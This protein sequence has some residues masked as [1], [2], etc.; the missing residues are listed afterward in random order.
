[1]AQII[2]TY[3]KRSYKALS[4]I[5][6]V[7]IFFLGYNTYLMDRSLNNLRFALEMTGNVKSFEDAK[8]ISKILE[9]AL[10]M[11]VS[12]KELL[13]SNIAK[14]ELAKEILSKPEN[15]S[16]IEKDAQKLA[17][18]LHSSLVEE[19]SYESLDD[20]NMPLVEF[21]SDIFS[22]PKDISQL[23]DARF[24][25]QEVVKKKEEKRSPILLA[26]DKIGRF[27]APPVTTIS[28]SRLR[29][30]LKRTQRELAETSDTTKRQELN[31]QLAALQ[32]Y[33]SEFSQ[34]QA[35]YQRV[36]DL[37]HE[38]DLA[39]KAQFNI[40]WNEKLRGNSEE[41]IRMFEALSQ[42]FGKE[43]IGVFS[44]YQ[45]AEILRKNGEY[46]KAVSAYQEVAS[47]QPQ[48]DLGKMATFQTGSTYL[49]DLKE[50]DK[51]EQ[52]FNQY[53]A[54]SDDSDLAVHVKKEVIP[55]LGK[56]YRQ[57]GFGLLEQGYTSK[58]SEKFAEALKNFE[59]ALEINSRDGFSYSGKA[60]V[61]L[62]LNDPDKA[63]QF[64]R[65]AVKLL[66]RNEVTGVNLGYIYIELKMFDAAVEE[67]RKFISVNPLTSRGY[68]NLG[69]AYAQKGKFEESTSAFQQAIQI[70]PLFALSYNNL[71]WSLLQ[72][73]RYGESLEALKRAVEIDPRFGDSLFNLGILYK[74]IGKYKDAAAAFQDVLRIPL[75]P[76]RAEAE[77]HLKEIESIIK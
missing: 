17:S 22:K 50:Y 60:L 23:N 39:K 8:K 65:E 67:Y 66:P 2:L 13:P 63:I 14:L 40:A 29:N 49:Y 69:Y 35:S 46:E 18:V 55:T 9:L 45:I 26:L 20:S 41:A 10:I 21:A 32:T 57:M 38:S 25:L 6:G 11:E 34:A 4:V 3:L 16:E 36:I 73:G 58:I 33:L 59:K 30:E 47:K 56:Q 7:I 52:I 74:A 72:L 77:R 12:S 61:F 48:T 28:K 31:Y 1:M 76:L 27:F 62:W 24:A 64:G 19:A 44:Q 53:K 5:V 37:N 54:L 51:A 68:Y 70:D 43:E 75:T 71:G 15:L 42:E